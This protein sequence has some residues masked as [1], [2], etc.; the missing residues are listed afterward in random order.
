M[1]EGMLPRISGIAGF[2]ILCF[3]SSAA[4]GV[5]RRELGFRGAIGSATHGGKP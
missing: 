4:G 1:A 2:P 3:N 5:R